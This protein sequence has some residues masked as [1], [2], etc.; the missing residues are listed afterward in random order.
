MSVAFILPRQIKI[1]SPV[2]ISSSKS[3]GQRVQTLPNQITEKIIRGMDPEFLASIDSTCP[4]LKQGAVLFWMARLT[5]YQVDAL[6][7]G[8]LISIKA[9]GAN[10]YSKSKEINVEKCQIKEPTT[11]KRSHELGQGNT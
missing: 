2:K 6:K 10:V 9:T 4:R 11:Q 5:E 8:G 7:K 1:H 3:S